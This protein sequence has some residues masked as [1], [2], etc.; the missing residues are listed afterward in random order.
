MV[1]GGPN[2]P[3]IFVAFDHD[4]KLIMVNSEKEEVA[5]AN[6]QILDHI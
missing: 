6:H 3:E 1:L 2:Q 4:V 5:I